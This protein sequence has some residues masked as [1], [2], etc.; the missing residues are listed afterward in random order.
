MAAR[1]NLSI[2]A[3]LRWSQVE[4]G[5]AGSTFHNN[6]SNALMSPEP[7]LLSKNQKAMAQLAPLDRLPAQMKSPATFDG[8]K[9]E[10]NLPS[11]E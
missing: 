4:E 2:P 11:K 5:Q 9:R 7:G 8:G 10:V 6:S 3:H 1:E